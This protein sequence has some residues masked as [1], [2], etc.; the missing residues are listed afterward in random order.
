MERIVFVVLHYETLDDTKKCIDSLLKYLAG[1]E[2]HIVAVDNGSA[3]GKLSALQD[4]YRHIPQ[5]HWIYSAKNLGFAK[6]NNL[7][8]RYAKYQLG[9][10]VIVLANND[11]VFEQK[12]FIE[13]LRKQLAQTGFDVAGPKIFSL[14]DSKNQNPVQVQ[15]KDRSGVL[16]RLI[17]YN[18]LYLSS[19][20]NMDILLKRKFAREIEEFVP[21][22]D[23]DFQLHGA[24]MIFAGD[25]LRRFDGLYDKTFMYGEENI[26]KHIVRCFGLKMCYLED[27]SVYHKEGSSTQAIWGKG[28]KS[29]RFY[30]RWNIHSCRLLSRLMRKKNLTDQ[31]MICQN[32]E[33]F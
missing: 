1:D 7:G 2:V 29:R 30:Y 31:E 24:C 22:A 25:Y 13:K 8:Y 12:D 18:I 14:V 27:V 15:Y 16:K 11:L 32:R 33:C 3:N 19:L 21:S 26:L 23:E 20:L 5:V 6:G 9:A 10:N 28:V 17:K 4:G